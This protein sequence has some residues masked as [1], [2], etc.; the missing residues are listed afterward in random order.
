MPKK[1]SVKKSAQEFL[2][3]LEEISNFSMEVSEHKLSKKSESWCYDLLIIRLYREFE[4]FMLNCLV[5]AINNDTSILSQKRGFDF[6]KHL[7]DEVCEYIITGGGF[8]DFRG[9]DGLIST[10]KKFL[11]EEHYLLQAIKRDEYRRSLEKLSALRNFA[12]HESPPS[13]KAALKAVELEKIGS[14]GSYLKSNG[15]ARFGMIVSD[16]ECL[17]SR[18]SQHAPF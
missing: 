18:I 7:T 6:P 1:K 10:L 8:F 16:L 12:A 3:A 2:I 17:A 9:R 14:A 15:G 5:A 4:R 13:K 11:P